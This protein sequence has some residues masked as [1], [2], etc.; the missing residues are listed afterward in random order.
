MPSMSLI[1]LVSVLMEPAIC[2][3]RHGVLTEKTAKIVIAHHPYEATRDDEISFGKDEVI[4]VTDDSDP[5][6]WVGKKKD[7]SLGFF[8][9]NFVTV[10]DDSSAGNEKPEVEQGNQDVIDNTEAHQTESVAVNDDTA[11]PLE[12]DNIHADTQ[13]EEPTPEKQKVDQVIGMAR[14][15]EDYASQEA[16]EISLPRG[17]IINVYEVIDDE[18]SRGELNGKVGRYPSKYVE[19]IDMPGRPDL[20]KQLSGGSVEGPRSPLSDEDN[21]APKGGFKLAAFGVKQG[22]IGS[23]LAGGFP[24]LKKTGGARKMAEPEPEPA[25]ETKRDVVSEESKPAATSEATSPTAFVPPVPAFTA[26]ED[27]FDKKPVVEEKKQEKS[28]GKAIVLH[29]YDADNEDELSL[30]RGEYVD[31][32]DRNA[33]DGWWLGKNE[34]GEY[35]VF[36]PNFVKE[37]EEDS[38]APPTP[39]RSRRSVNTGSV[40]SAAESSPVMAKPPQVPRP[41]SV[42]TPSTARP[43][44]LNQR[45]SSVQTP[46][47]NAPPLATPPK[48]FTAPIS[49]GTS[50]PITEETEETEQAI[51]EEEQYDADEEKPSSPVKSEVEESPAFTPVVAEHPLPAAIIP[52]KEERKIDSPVVVEEDP[53]SDQEEKESG[54]DEAPFMKEEEKVEQSIESPS[55][56]EADESDILPKHTNNDDPTTTHVVSGD[57][58]TETK[59]EKED[60]VVIE[61]ESEEEF[62]EASEEATPIISEQQPSIVEKENEADAL[63]IEKK[64]EI[65]TEKNEPT[66]KELKEDDG[67]PVVVEEEKNEFDTIPSGPKLSAPTRARLGGRARRSP[68]ALH[69]EPSQM[70]TLQKELEAEEKEEETKK[71]AVPEKPASPPAKP[72]KPIFAKFPTPFAAGAADEISKRN[73]KPTQARRLWDEKPAEDKPVSTTEQE[74]EPVRPSGVKNIASRFN[75]NGGGGGSNEVLETKLKNHTKNEVEK[76]RKEFEL[77][78]QEERDKRTQLETTVAELIEKIKSL[79]N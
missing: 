68:Q 70:E 71:P 28:L 55:V 44:T 69:S 8:P 66:A 5:D 10:R 50:A 24:G 73:L 76:V 21:S 51:K 64:E 22:G 1:Y 79:E 37:L 14:V 43:V 34:R 20:G 17:G 35:G 54:V 7:G 49:Q 77:L 41:A 36:P 33:D 57:I 27:T 59:S 53:I 67:V 78:L 23:L 72:I 31:I 63:S 47:S 48:P 62:K 11:K 58:P 29:P 75:F 65:D 42:Q 18:W 74:P 2:L 38:F 46:S 40:S 32:L 13:A 52:E 45:P 12:E 4:K 6:W 30:L 9:S 60:S 19:D 56:I 15:M 39:T 16:G 3:L 26:S 61:E 25:V